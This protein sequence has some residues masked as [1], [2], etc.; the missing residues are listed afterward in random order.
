MI[1]FRLL[2][3]WWRKQWWFGLEREGLHV[4]KVEVWCCVNDKPQ[5]L[6]V[7]TQ[8]SNWFKLPCIP[9]FRYWLYCLVKRNIISFNIE[10]GFLFFSFHTSIF[11]KLTSSDPIVSFFFL[12]FS[13]CVCRENETKS[14]LEMQ[15]FV[16]FYLYVSA[17]QCRV[18]TKWW[19]ISGVLISMFEFFNV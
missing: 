12:F 4:S 8:E 3:E 10:N 9:C 19:L 6:S 14:K 18:D 17:M 5:K 2:Y 1:N 16:W 13:F 15:C 7:V 11:R